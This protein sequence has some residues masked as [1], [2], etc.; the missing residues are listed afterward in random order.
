MNSKPSR[1]SNS[2]D[3]LGPRLEQKSEIKTRNRFVKV[4]SLITH[5]KTRLMNVIAA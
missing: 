3:S 4:H 5:R 2:S 1:F